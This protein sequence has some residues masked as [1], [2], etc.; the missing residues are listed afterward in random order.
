MVTLAF[1]FV[2]TQMHVE[3]YIY[4]YILLANCISI[5][6]IIILRRMV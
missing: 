1:K 2:K 4:G 5:N 3:I 6:L